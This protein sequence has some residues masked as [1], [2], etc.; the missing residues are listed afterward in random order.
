MQERRTYACGRLREI[1][2]TEGVTSSFFSSEDVPIESSFPVLLA[3]LMQ[4]K[5]DEAMLEKSVDGLRL[6]KKLL[7]E[8]GV[9]NAEYIKAEPSVANVYG[10][11]N[12]FEKGEIL[13]SEESGCLIK[14]EEK[15]RDIKFAALLDSVV[16]SARM[17]S[18]PISLSTYKKAIENANIAQGM[19]IKYAK[20]QA[21]RAVDYSVK[22]SEKLFDE[23]ATNC[24]RKEALK[25]RQEREEIL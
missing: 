12:R 7:D 4:E 16:V 11:L 23:K 6:Y 24:F 20:I 22:L 13:P 19:P 3:N 8:G 10:F 14:V 18:K 2:K 25:R 5:V 1:L 21:E 9:E 15:L 17:K